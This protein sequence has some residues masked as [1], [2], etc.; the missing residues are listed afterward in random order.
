MFEGFEG[1]ET[2][3]TDVDGVRVHARVGG[4]G[5]PVLLLHG[6]PSSSH[7]FRDLIPLLAD[8]FHIIAPDLPGFG[9]TAMPSREAFAYTFDSLARVVGR[10]TERVGFWSDIENAFQTGTPEYIERDVLATLHR[11]DLQTRLHGKDLLPSGG[12]YT[13][14]AISRGLA[15]FVQ[16]D[17]VGERRRLDEFD[18][19]RLRGRLTGRRAFFDELF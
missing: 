8:R 7:M 3:D 16:A 2:T 6:F 18:Q 13:V 4:S 1:F 5:P 15:K 19:A 10:F 14:E 17:E 12:E 11:H 9:R